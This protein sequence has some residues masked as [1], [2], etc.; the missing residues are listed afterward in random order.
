MVC[1]L[2]NIE[3]HSN[4]VSQFQHAEQKVLLSSLHRIVFW[5]V[6]MYTIRRNELSVVMLD[7]TTKQKRG[8]SEKY[9]KNLISGRMV[10][11]SAP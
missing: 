5:S 2:L 1:L 6:C 11:E 8:E 10:V 9:L 4:L 3:S 7:K